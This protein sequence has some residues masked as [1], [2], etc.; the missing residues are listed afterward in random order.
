M[1]DLAQEKYIDH[2]VR[3]R[4]LEQTYKDTN[5]LLRWILTT[6]ITIGMPILLHAFNFI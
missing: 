5:K 1:I 2:E 3:I 4:M 6:V